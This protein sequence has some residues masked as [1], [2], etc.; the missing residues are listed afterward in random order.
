MD[1][2]MLPRAGCIA[3]TQLRVTARDSSVSTS[4][5]PAEAMLLCVSKLYFSSK[6][7]HLQH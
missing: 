1:P 5:P 2:G 4:Y 6:L 7:A 3:A